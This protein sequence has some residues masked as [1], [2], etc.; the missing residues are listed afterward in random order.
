MAAAMGAA[1]VGGG[2]RSAASLA[3]I[4]PAKWERAELKTAATAAW[5]E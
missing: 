5:A 1:S 2:G 4:R 3:S